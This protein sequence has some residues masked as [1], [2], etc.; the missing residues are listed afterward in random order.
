MIRSY[1]IGDAR[2][3]ALRQHLV[4]HDAPHSRRASQICG[5]PAKSGNPWYDLDVTT[6]D[7]SER[8]LDSDGDAESYT[9][10][11]PA[12][13]RRGWW[14]GQKYTGGALAILLILLFLA[15][16]F[17]LL[18]MVVLTEALIHRTIG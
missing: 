17:I 3:R 4:T 2:R 5:I 1:A 16:P 13:A 11:D 18:F 8:V 6:P 7:D 12:A 14:P 10:A 9:A 15:T